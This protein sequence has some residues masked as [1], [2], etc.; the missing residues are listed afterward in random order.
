MFTTLII[1]SSMASA[2]AFSLS[3]AR[4]SS[5]LKMSAEGMVGQLAPVGFFDPL[6][7]SAG[8]SSG[9][10]KKIRESEL[11]HGESVLTNAICS[12]TPNLKRPWFLL[13]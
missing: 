13:R 3:S 1:A 11:K 8:K 10:L 6:G 2:C 5:S 7:F 12:V 4:S 9:E